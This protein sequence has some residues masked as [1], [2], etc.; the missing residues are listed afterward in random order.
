MKRRIGIDAGGTLT[1]LVYSERNRLHFKTYQMDETSEL[2]NWLNMVGDDCELCLT[3][4]KAPQVEK[5]SMR[6]W[7]HI[8]EFTALVSGT[9]YLLETEQRSSIKEY[10][11]V[12]IGTGTSFFYVTPDGFERL[13]GSGLGGGTLLG[14]GRLLTGS[15]DFRDLTAMA[16]EGDSSRI[17][18]LVKD[19]YQGD[20][21]LMDGLTAA[22]FGKAYSQKVIAADRAAGLF[23]MIGEN[24]LLLASQAA[25][26]KQSKYI[27][28][29]GSTLKSNAP[30]KKILAGFKDMLPLEKVF[31]EKGSHAGALGAWLDR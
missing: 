21:P 11:L 26:L 17:D 13:L 12:N 5:K 6:T 23:R 2:I 14:L 9:Q 25:M 18:L 24:L 30:L 10:I 3:G 15:E 20:T 1:K 7:R 19:I 22:N 29:I 28:F 8:D 27:V 4:G 31:P 16:T